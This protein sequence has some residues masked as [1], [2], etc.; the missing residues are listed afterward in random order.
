MLRGTVLITGGSGFLGR[1]IMQQAEANGWDCSFIVYSRDEYKQDLCKKKYPYVRYVLGDI[2]DYDRLVDT[3][4]LGRVDTV[5]HTAAIK[6]IPEAEFNASECIDVNVRGSEVVLRAATRSDHVR[7]VLMIST[8]KA[9]VPINVYGASKMLMERLACEY[10]RLCNEIHIGLCRYGNVI[11][12]TGSVIPKFLEQKAKGKLIVTDPAMTRYWI[13]IEEAVELIVAAQHGTSGSIIVPKP[14]AMKLGD[15]AE[16]LAD[17]V[18]VE[19]VGLRP[20]EKMHEQLM[21]QQE[22]IRAVDKRDHYELFPPYFQA[23]GEPFELVS[24]QPHR[25]LLPDELLRHTEDAARV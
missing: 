2:K 9:C 16:T 18:P 24:N 23:V 8:D 10:A 25:W 7:Q 14:A 3:L 4:M 12:S 22:S 13:S 1:G 20:G 17:G 11:G 15:M 5:I 19:I 21:H 6:Y